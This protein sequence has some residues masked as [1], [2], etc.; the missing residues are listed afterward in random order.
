MSSNCQYV[1][2]ECY[3]TFFN[4]IFLLTV[5]NVFLFCFGYNNVEKTLNKNRGVNMVWMKVW[6][7][8]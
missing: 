5:N 2:M 6:N 4:P 3:S 8:S 1:I 7:S